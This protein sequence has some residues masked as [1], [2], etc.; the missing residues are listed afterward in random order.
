MSGRPTSG[1]LFFAL[2]WHLQTKPSLKQR[3][4]AVHHRRA[5]RG[6]T[7][8][9]TP[10]LLGGWGGA[11]RS[12]CTLTPV[13]MRAHPVSLGWCHICVLRNIPSGS[14]THTHAHRHKT[15]KRFGFGCASFLMH[16]PLLYRL[17]P[18][19]AGPGPIVL[20]LYIFNDLAGVFFHATVGAL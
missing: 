6:Q 3:C 1:F 7:V 19:P 14:H 16:P 4:S 15:A 10:S 5:L 18:G 13:C 2:S 17:R 8:N 20:T 9:P 11:G 12:T